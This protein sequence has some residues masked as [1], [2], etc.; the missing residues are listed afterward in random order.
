MNIFGLH[1]DPE[2]EFLPT[3]VIGTEA[4]VSRK[5]PV[6]FSLYGKSVQLF[7]VLFKPYINL[8][9]KLSLR[10]S[11]CEVITMQPCLHV[12]KSEMRIKKYNISFKSTH[13][14]EEVRYI[15]V[16]ARATN[17]YEKACHLHNKGFGDSILKR[18]RLRDKYMY[19]IHQI[20]LQKASCVT[21][22]VLPEPSRFTA[23]TVIGNRTGRR[24]THTVCNHYF[25]V[26]NVEEM[27]FRGYYLNNFLRRDGSEI[28]ILSKSGAMLKSNVK[29][30][31]VIYFDMSG[32]LT[33][34][35]FALDMDYYS[36]PLALVA[37]K[38]E[39]VA[40]E[41]FKFQLAT[42]KE[43]SHQLIILLSS[44]LSVNVPKVT[45]DIHQCKT[46]RYLLLP[47]ETKREKPAQS[48][49]KSW[50]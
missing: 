48:F 40:T 33:L 12:D 17:Y 19:Y 27:I 25:I 32:E 35:N 42:I 34:L 38:T 11:S 21:L 23:Y 1:K 16:E 8:K 15:R 31:R 49:L 13:F 3:A 29:N 30:E 26:N 2:K 46:P 45:N 4:D 6:W 43:H 14:A 28:N 39:Q 50:R 36:S 20:Y 7:L 18:K 41:N 47:I 24:R 5:S 37:R 10:P 9:V 22:Q 44:I